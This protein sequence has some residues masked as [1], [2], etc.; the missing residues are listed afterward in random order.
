MSIYDGYDYITIEH[1]QQEKDFVGN[2]LH[3]MPN[4][5]A[6]LFFREE[7]IKKINDRLIEEIMVI[8]KDK[9]GKSVRIKPQESK[10]MIQIMRYVYF[11]K[12]QN[13][14]NVQKELEYLNNITLELLLPTV[15]NGL[16]AQIK[17]LETYDR[18]KNIPLERPKSTNNK[19]PL[20]PMT[21]LFGF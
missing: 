2:I 7:N 19:A 10:L 1:S 14:N 6:I 16:V 15:Y 8:S 21:R 11:D 4:D 3:I 20:R 12:I 9:M 18:Q 5:L 17:Y 13:C